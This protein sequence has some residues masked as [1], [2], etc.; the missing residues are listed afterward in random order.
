MPKGR[1]KESKNKYSRATP[2]RKSKPCSVCKQEK[3]PSEFYPNK[4][5]KDKLSTV[6][7]QCN[8]ETCFK[9]R[10]KRFIR[11]NGMEA[12]GWKLRELRRQLKLMLAVKKELE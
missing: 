2:E 5:S 3:L 9:V 12:Y 4:S 11:S 8:S 7:I 6:C 10:Q 1:P